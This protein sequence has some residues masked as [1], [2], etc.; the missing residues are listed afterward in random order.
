[1][2][3]FLMAKYQ[4]PNGKIGVIT[5][6]SNFLSGAKDREADNYHLIYVGSP[7]N[8]TWPSSGNQTWPSRGNETWSSLGNLA[9]SSLG[10]RAWPI[11]IT[12]DFY[13]PWAKPGLH[14]WPRV[15][16][17]W[18]KLGP[19]SGPWYF[20]VWVSMWLSNK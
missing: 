3:K 19:S 4:K 20:P 6:V 14:A 1:M 15:L 13:P 8:R 17:S 5:A 7:G 10:N 9:W 16:H 12:P 2:E 18:A 11:V